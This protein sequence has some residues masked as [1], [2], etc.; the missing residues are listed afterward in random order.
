MKK[1]TKNQA[2][3][4]VA[5]TV[6]WFLMMATCYGMGILAHNIGHEF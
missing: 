2:I 3:V 1:F 6:L 5:G 4:I